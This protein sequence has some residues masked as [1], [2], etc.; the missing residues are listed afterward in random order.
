MPRQ[1]PGKK[2]LLVGVLVAV[3]VA[4]PAVVA[5]TVTSTTRSVT[6]TPAS[7]TT[8]FTVPFHFISADHLVVTK[9]TIASGAKS[10]LTRGPDY[11][12]TMPVGSV[13]GSI[14]T[15]VAVTN[16][17]TLTI[18]RFVPLTQNT[19]FSSLSYSPQRMEDAFDLT[20]MQIQ[21]VNASVTGAGG[22]AG[23]VE[24][25]EGKADPHAQYALLSGR[26]GGQHLR[27]GTGSGNSLQLSSTSH[28][29]K[30]GIFLGSASVYDDAQDRLGVGTTNPLATLH[31]Q[32]AALMSSVYTTQVSGDSSSL[33]LHSAPS[34]DGLICL[35]GDSCYDEST[36]SLGVGTTSPS[37]TLDVVGDAVF[38]GDDAT[39][40]L[41]PTGANALVQHRSDETDSAL[42]VIHS[43]AAGDF[44]GSSGIVAHGPSHATL[45]STLLLVSSQIQFTG[46]ENLGRLDQNGLSLSVPL[47]GRRGLKS[48]SVS[49][50]LSATPED[51]DCGSVVLAG[52]DNTVISLPVGDEDLVGCEITIIVISGT[53]TTRISIS[54]DNESEIVG[55]CLQGGEGGFESWPLP[56]SDLGKDVFVDKSKQEFG[57]RI[58]LLYIGNSAW[59]TTSC[60][61][62]WEM[63]D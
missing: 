21:Q 47:R 54:P 49:E 27:G 46:E 39:L 57:D 59:L 24:A 58:S 34:M 23:D 10:T 32:G 45:P 11:T 18:D 4:I 8:S 20:A 15:T 43:N 60:V 2:L 30:G 36:L 22:G 33:V 61:G 40:V 19:D 16:T 53:E 6:Y 12:V 25:H 9:T 29:T 55:S 51:N 50:V 7:P 26:S 52:I 42:R 41:D 14:T 38:S 62:L 13:Q 56:M 63:E 44:A 31:V 35:G 28:G 17:H 3:A 37:A 1:E 48:A 5:A